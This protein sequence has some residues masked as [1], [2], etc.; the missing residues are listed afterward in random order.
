MIYKYEQIGDI[1]ISRVVKGAKLLGFIEGEKEIEEAYRAVIED[2][3]PQQYKYYRLKSKYSG[4]Y[5]ELPDN[6]LKVNE[7]IQQ[8][9]VNN[10]NPL[11]QTFRIIPSGEDGYY[12]I[13]NAGSN[14]A[15]TVEGQSLDDNAPLIQVGDHNKD[16]QMFK[17]EY[18]KNGAYKIQAK[19]SG[20]YV[21]IK[22]DS[23]SE[24]AWIVQWPYKTSGVE[25]Q[26]W[27][28]EEVQNTYE[29][30]DDFL[31]KRV[32]EDRMITTSVLLT[33]AKGLGYQ[34]DEQTIESK[35]NELLNVNGS[36]I[37]S[38]S[39]GFITTFGMLNQPL[40]KIGFAGAHNAFSNNQ[41][42]RSSFAWDTYKTGHSLGTEN[43][44]I[45]IK[46]M[47]EKGYRVIDL[48][49]GNNGN[50]NTGCY[51]RYRLAGYSNLN[52]NNAILPKIKAFLD[53][54]ENEIVIIHLSDVYNGTIDLTKLKNQSTYHKGE[55]SYNKQLNNLFEDMSNTG[56][57]SMTYN[58]D[59]TS[60]ISHD[61]LYKHMKVPGQDISWPTIKEMLQSGKRILFIERDEGIAKD[62]WFKN[63][64]GDPNKTTPE[65]L[66]VTQA[67]LDDFKSGSS[68]KFINITCKRTGVHQL[69]I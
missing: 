5:I 20:K 42:R 30:L 21:T 62:I 64:D 8:G 47:L 50:G 41:D 56:L 66:H 25:N 34:V 16:H 43:H 15:F 26:S 17:F 40:D 22:S 9:A 54:N 63:Q 65:N 12:K 39:T 28:L 49:I 3:K 61:D 38:D 29:S 18:E 55:E 58:F 1:D 4:L 33:N 24:G 59:G 11:G 13:I 2:H 68:N 60:G 36:K 52:G 31:E 19:H 23:K 44:K 53:E 14:M 67:L 45:S 48:D 57:L 6:S 46:T 69:E 51:H 35:V 37:F 10:N 32:L 27:I 7:H